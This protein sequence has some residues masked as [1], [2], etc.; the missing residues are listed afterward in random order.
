MEETTWWSKLLIF[1][2]G[3]SVFLLVSGPMGYKT[4][5]TALIPSLM[6]LLVAVAAAML[7]FL[8]SVIL[9]IVAIKGDLV[10]DRNLILIAM[11]ICVVPIVAMLPQI[12]KARSVPPIHD[13][14]TDTRSPPQFDAVIALREDAA[15]SL[16][17][18][19]EGS[20]AKLAEETLGAYPELKPLQTPL[21]VAEA[22]ERSVEVLTNQGLEIVNSNNESGI[23]EATATTFWFGFKDDLVVRVVSDGSGSKIDVRSV[24]RVGQSDIGANAER[25][26]RF[27][28]AF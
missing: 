18:Q 16:D 15:N 3:L 21:S 20:V 2:A 9:V 19:Y 22:V 24:S 26:A 4:G 13:I 12:L 28:D 25:I 8:A 6:S 14:S 10:K 23:V 5:I 1:S 17:Y 27:L 7:V 11:V